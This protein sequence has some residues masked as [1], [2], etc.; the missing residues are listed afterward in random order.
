MA[1]HR[2]TGTRADFYSDHDYLTAILRRIYENG[3]KKAAVDFDKEASAIMASLG[4]HGR[5]LH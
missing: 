3:Q 2:D 4:D 5:E 1:D